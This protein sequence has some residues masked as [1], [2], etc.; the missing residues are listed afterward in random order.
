VLGAICTGVYFV[1]GVIVAHAMF[2][3]P[4]RDDWD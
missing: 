1:C 4:Q 3:A 2:T